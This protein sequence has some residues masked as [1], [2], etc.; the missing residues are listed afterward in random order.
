MNEQVDI[1]VLKVHIDNL[2]RECEQRDQQLS[3]RMDEADKRI[4][5]R[6]AKNESTL[7]GIR[8]AI[9]EL[10]T[11]AKNMRFGFVVVA[12]VGGIAAWV[13]DL[14]GKISGWFK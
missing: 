10:D 11:K 12:G 2:R 4:E 8:S 6:L 5:D 14:A 3:R 9:G 7:D 1:A 13:I